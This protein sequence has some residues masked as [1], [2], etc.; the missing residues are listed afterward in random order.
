[1]KLRRPPSPIFGRALLL[2]LSTLGDSEWVALDDLA[3]QLDCA[4]SGMEPPVQ[5]PRG[6]GRFIA[7]RE[8]SC[9]ADR[10]SRND[11]RL[12]AARDCAPRVDPA[13]SR[14][15]AGLD[16]RRQWKHRSGAESCN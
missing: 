7:P 15:S 10:R 13:G 9:A 11:R 3:A 4:L 14:L 2:W 1:M 5:E 6:S 12:A 16:S 8:T